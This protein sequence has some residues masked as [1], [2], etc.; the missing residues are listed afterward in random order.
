MRPIDKLSTTGLLYSLLLIPVI[1]LFIAS[2]GKDSPAP[3]PPPPVPVINTISPIHGPFNTSIIITGTN[4]SVT[5]A[6][7]IVKVNGKPA[8]VTNATATQLTVNVPVGAGTGN[9]SVK[10]NSSEISGPVF[11][12]EYTAVVSTVG[13]TPTSGDFHYPAGVAV[14]NQDN[15]YVTDMTL[16]YIKKISPA[17]VVSILA[18]NGAAGGFVD[19]TGT[20][21]RFN[22]PYGLKCDAQGNIYVCDMYNSSIRKVTPAGVVTTLAGNGVAGYA[23]GTGNSARFNQPT[24]LTFD[25][26]GNIYIADRWN[27]RIR[28]L[29]PAGQVSTVVYNSIPP[30]ASHGLIIDAPGTIF[31]CLQGDHVVMK[32]TTDGNW[33]EF[34]TAGNPGFFDSHQ[35]WAKFNGP[36]D[37]IKDAQGIIYVADAANSAIRKILPDGQVIT[38][39]GNGVQGYMDDAGSAARFK[40]PIGLALDKNGNLF[41]ADSGNHVVRKITFK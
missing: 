18:G 31:S 39:A 11:T 35:S 4:F 6:E 16:N 13:G 37:V 20:A 5:A 7:N 30:S 15:I 36:S 21:A 25:G 14:D 2:C 41:I 40:S 1:M 27:N 12:Y 33:T 28:K 29:T 26:S 32:Y 24:C 8:T 23:D 38:I 19:G 34:G 10:V 9:V 3:A 22:Y 17:G